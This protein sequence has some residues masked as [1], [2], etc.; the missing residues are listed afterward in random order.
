MSA[1]DNL[2]VTGCALGL[3]QRDAETRAM[4]LIEDLSLTRIMDLDARQLSGG[5]Q[6]LL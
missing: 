3:S 5:Q 4:S 6:K 2:L 1:F